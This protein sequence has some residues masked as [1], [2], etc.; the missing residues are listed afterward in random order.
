VAAA[1][2]VENSAR[3]EETV[4]RRDHFSTRQPIIRIS[5]GVQPFAFGAGASD[6]KHELALI[7]RLAEFAE[8]G[9]LITARCPCSA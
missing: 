6:T 5:P 9:Q 7:A 8:A 4:Q 2:D 3:S 1:A